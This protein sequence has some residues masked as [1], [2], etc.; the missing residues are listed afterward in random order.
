M[1]NLT[2]LSLLSALALL[3]ACAAQQP[4]WLND[5]YSEHS[6]SRYLVAVASADNTNDADNRALAGL[7]RTFEVAIKERSKD[8]SSA[9]VERING[10]QVMHNE[11][12]ASRS[13]NAFTSQV[14]EG[15]MIDQ[16]WLSKQG[17]HYSLATLNKSE[18][19]RR[20]RGRLNTLDKDS[21][22]LASR[23]NSGA[24]IVQRLSAL[25]AARTLQLERLQINR[26][27][28]VV[29]KM[30]K[31]SQYSEPY[32]RSR[33]KQILAQQRFRVQAQKSSELVPLLTSAV[34][35]VGSKVSDTGSY[36][37]VGRLDSNPI[38]QRQKW[39]WLHASMELNLQY[40][41]KV[42]AKQRWSVKTSATQKEMVQS[43]MLDK[44][45]NN[46]ANYFYT[47][48]TSAKVER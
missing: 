20:F 35:H 36:T 47:L 23:G 4:K 31:T 26:N 28:S 12:N 16:R 15:A 27:L 44:L 9:S 48:L 19:A 8:E 11:V 7:A 42:I 1:N 3:S 38:V 18:A 39:F 29:A 30:G 21:R 14:L 25:E 33:I 37:L 32:F 46:M 45:S 24:N 34:H 41:G 40:N 10:K 13:L 22:W 6:K 43:R 5:P 17:R 2:L